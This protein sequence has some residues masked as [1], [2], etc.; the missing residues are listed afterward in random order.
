MA[1]QGA[2][3]ANSPFAGLDGHGNPYQSFGP[4]T[5]FR[6]GYS[7]MTGVIQAQNYQDGNSLMAMGGR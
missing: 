3:G 2:S 7:V 6:P 5:P 1:M 4:F